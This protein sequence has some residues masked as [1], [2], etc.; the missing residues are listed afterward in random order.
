MA[1][2]AALQKGIDVV[3]RWAA[4]LGRTLSESNRLPSIFHACGFEAIHHDV[5]STDCDASTRTELTVE[6]TTAFQPLFVRY[7]QM[8]GSGI[9]VAEAVKV[10]ERMQKEAKQGKAYLRFDFNI[11]TGRKPEGLQDI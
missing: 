9:T 4:L 6:M 7:A 2:K 3:R 8:D 5:M 10:G 11:V 1:P